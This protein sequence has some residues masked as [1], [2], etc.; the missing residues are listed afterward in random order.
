MADSDIVNA[1]VLFPVADDVGIEG[2]ARLRLN[3]VLSNSR[4]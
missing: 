3:M 4:L 1:L 2:V